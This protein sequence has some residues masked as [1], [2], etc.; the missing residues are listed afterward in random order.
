MLQIPAEF[1][2][3]VLELPARRAERRSH[4]R[5]LSSLRRYAI[6][7]SLFKP[8]TLCTRH[9]QTGLRTSRSDPRAGPRSGSD[10]APPRYRL[11]RR[12]SRA[13]LPA[14]G[15]GGGLF[16]QLWL[17]AAR[18]SRSDASANAAPSAGARS[19]AADA[20][21]LLEF[22]GEQGTAHPRAVDSH[23]AH[24]KI[25]N[26][27]GGS[28]NATTR[29]LDEM[30]YRGLLRVA[31][32]DSGTRVYAARRADADPRAGC[33][34][35]RE[36]AVDR[37]STHWWTSSSGKYAP[38]PA[39]SLGQL[40][41]IL[42][43][44]VPAV[45]D[46]PRGVPRSAPSGASLGARIDGIDWYWPAGETP[47]LG[48]AGDRTSRGEAAD[49]VRSGGLGPAPLRA[50]L[51]LAVSLRGVYTGGEAQARL[52]R[53]ATAVGRAGDR[54]GQS[55]RTRGL[56]AER[57]RLSR[58]PAAARGRVPPSARGGARAHAHFSA[59]PARAIQPRQ[60]R[61]RPV[62]RCTK[63]DWR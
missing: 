36:P 58:G 18:A 10:A 31:R 48:A 1:N 27:F 53:I 15:A 8:T 33:R 52:L 29:L 45:G 32:R 51:G 4:R 25:T 60:V 34:G 47:G 41:R 7:R 56:A 11:P 40:L 35:R 3:A 57:V 24:G 61:N 22:I 43:G 19:R 59:E 42:R 39:R 28:T 63:S 38:L 26:W 5:R 55:L 14:S 2:A 62:S 49:A 30:H 37:V 6:A 21:A 46:T 9:P 16:R 54:L 50:L 17:S 23:F 20:R 12:R 13:P 44:G